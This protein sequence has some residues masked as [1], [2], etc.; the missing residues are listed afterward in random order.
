MTNKLQQITILTLTAILIT[1]GFSITQ[2]AYSTGSN[3]GNNWND[4][5]DDEQ[6][7]PKSLC[8]DSTN[9]ITNGCFEKPVVTN[10]K[11]WNIYNKTIASDL[12]WDVMWLKD[13]DD[14]KVG[15]NPCLPGEYGY[16]SSG[17]LE[18]QKGILDGPAE[19][20]QHAELD[21]D[22][23]GPNNNV[24]SGEYS[25]VGISQS[26]S[27][28]EMN[29]YKITFAYKARPDQP[30][31][32]NG[33]VVSWNGADVTPNLDFSKKNW[34]YASIIVGVTADQDLTTLTFEDTGT[35]DS[36]GT[37][38]DDVSVR[39][40]PKPVIKITLNKEIDNSHDGTI[41]DPNAFGLKINGVGV[42]HGV[43]NIYQTAGPFTISEVGAD[44]YVGTLVVSENC[45]FESLGGTVELE[46]GDVV[47]CTILNT[48]VPLP[49]IT[50]K[51]VI[52]QDNTD[53]TDEI[54]LDVENPFHLW[55]TNTETN[56]EIEITME[57]QAVPQ[58]TYTL[59]EEIEEGLDR[60]EFVLITGDDGCPTLVEDMEEF[61]LDSGE[62]LTCVVYNEDDADSTSG[63]EGVIFQRN[64]MKV[65]LGDNTALDSCDKYTNP[66]DKDPCI[67]IISATSGIVGIVDSA[68]TS[69]T[70]IVLFSVIEA[71]RLETTTGAI[72]P[73]CSISAITQ[74]NKESFFLKDSDDT[75]PT[76]PTTSNV[77]V[78]K[79]VGM[80]ISGEDP[81]DPSMTYTP[82]YNINYVMIDPTA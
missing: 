52:T 78:L 65:T 49:T 60:F 58:G 74:H 22:C 68:L 4:H 39:P 62:H 43:E 80:I 79:C 37:F 9:L 7:I 56:E 13:I 67:E 54:D 24:R 15:N 32:T 23:N 75:F 20:Y 57:N 17:L 26:I 3:Y 34:K 8:K 71:D 40:I 44:N 81:N 14:V 33:L 16:G 72:N 1:G 12:G 64:S 31:S 70:T 38:L 18:L 5:D 73:V 51:K 19:G 55:I 48:F 30:L 82:V 77:V 42:S 61:T 63:G 27:T 47:E 2:V 76:N 41:T 10:S 35:P 21:S 29:D 45:P 6:S 28:S 46:L 69:D 53:E 11:K 59:R 36:F 25:S 50:L 66:A